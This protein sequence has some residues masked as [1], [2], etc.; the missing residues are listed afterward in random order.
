M[1]FLTAKLSPIFFEIDGLFEIRYYALFILTGALLAYFLS[2]YFFKRDGNDPTAIENIFFL[3]FPAG[4]LGA[5]IWFTFSELS[6][7]I[8][9][10]TWDKVLLKFI[11]IWEPGLAIQG[12]VMLGAIVG[13]YLYKKYYP[14][15]T[16]RYGLDIAIPNILIAQAIG[17]WGNFFNQEV[18]G[19]CVDPSSLSFLPKF[20]VDQMTANGAYNNQ[21]TCPL[22]LAAQPLFLYEGLLNTLG[23]IL[24]SLVLRFYWK[25][26]RKEGDL[27]MLYFIWYGTVRALLEPLRQEEFIMRIGGLSLSVWT[28]TAFMLFGLIGMI[29]FR[30]PEIKKLIKK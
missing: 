5:K 3:A 6:N 8:A 2:R 13:I 17:R 25:K 14:K 12:G 1:N 22:G 4:I 24:I 18:Y 10:Y 27:A 20:I 28:S 30:F 16:I 9:W 23:F 26:G 29:F 7:Y 11:A 19:S 21:I 15:L